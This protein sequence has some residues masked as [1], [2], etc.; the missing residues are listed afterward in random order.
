MALYVRHTSAVWIR[1]DLW[2]E[3]SGKDSTILYLLLS[4]IDLIRVLMVI[5]A[6]VCRE[7][8]YSIYQPQSA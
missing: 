1:F 3:N 2:A 8:S 4:C 7:F 5:S 6:L